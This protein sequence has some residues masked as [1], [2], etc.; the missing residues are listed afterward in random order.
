M[1]GNV[2]NRIQENVKGQPTPEVG[3]GATECCW[4][5]RHAYTIIEVLTPTRIVVQQDKAI[6]TDK[7]GMSDCQDYR[8]EP[9]PKAA[10]EELVFKKTKRVPHGRWVRKHEGIKGTPFVVGHRDE[11]HDYSF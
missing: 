11:H 7:N 10:K 9:N 8:Y 6:R 4:S 2:I 5:D 1:Y 3:M